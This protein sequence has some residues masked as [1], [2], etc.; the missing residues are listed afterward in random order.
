MQPFLPFSHSHSISTSLFACP[1]I[2]H[3]LPW[4]DRVSEMEISLD[5]ASAVLK[6]AALQMFGNRAM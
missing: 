6:D 2:S 5:Y 1:S 4:R 3:L